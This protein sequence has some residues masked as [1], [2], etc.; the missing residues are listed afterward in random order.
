MNATPASA[1]SSSNAAR[2]AA[3]RPAGRDGAGRSDARERFDRL[4]QQ[5]G[6]AGDDEAAPPPDAQA[7][8]ALTAAALRLRGAAENSPGDAVEGTA[9][10]AAAAGLRGHAQAEAAGRAAAARTQESAT[11]EALQRALSPD[12][13]QAAQEASLQAATRAEVLAGAQPARQFEVTLNDPLGLRLQLQATQAATGVPTHAAERGHAP[14]TVALASQRS[15][16]QLASRHLPRL[17]ER[18][19]A[20]GLSEGPVHLQRDEDEA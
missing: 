3:R 13:V 5:K 6:S 20:R 19:R 16:F 18:L 12:A 4:L 17:E 10:C 11:S 14:W 1:P 8:T 15:D 2:D 7:V 9:G